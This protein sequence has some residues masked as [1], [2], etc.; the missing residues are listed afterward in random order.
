MKNLLGLFAYFKRIV[1]NSSR[2]LIDKKEKN[3]R[4]SSIPPLPP[5]AFSYSLRKTG[6]N[7]SFLQN[8]VIAAYALFELYHDQFLL[9]SPFF[10]NRNPL[11]N[12]STIVI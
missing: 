12:A 8:V 1:R 2:L 10:E 7:C 3:L 5:P 6:S 9:L 4:H 11:D